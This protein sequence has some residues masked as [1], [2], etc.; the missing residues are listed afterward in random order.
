MEQNC[1]LIELIAE[2]FPKIIKYVNQQIQETQHWLDKRKLRHFILN[3]WL[4]TINK[5]NILKAA[6]GKYTDEHQ[7]SNH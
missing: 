4:K 1:K 3:L 5:E 6:R 7:R 2:N